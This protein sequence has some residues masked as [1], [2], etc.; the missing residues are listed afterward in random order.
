MVHPVG[1]STACQKVESHPTLLF[2]K[3]DKNKQAFNSAQASRTSPG[4]RAFARDALFPNR[5]TAAATSL[6]QK[7]LNYIPHV[8]TLLKYPN[9]TIYCGGIRWMCRRSA[10]SLGQWVGQRRLCRECMTGIEA[11]NPKTAND[12][13]GQQPAL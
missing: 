10:R 12:R 7:L 6:M 2:G 1:S 4:C 3:V 8:N 13:S 11:K 5:Q 9:I